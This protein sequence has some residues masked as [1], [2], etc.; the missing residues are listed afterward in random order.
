[1]GLTRMALWAGIKPAN[2]PETIKMTK[3]PVTTP[4][5]TLGLMNISTGPTLSSKEL[6]PKMTKDPNMIPTIP[7]IK[8]RKMDSI[9]IC[10][11][12]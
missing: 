7:D 8:V 4:T 10:F 6:M 3:A 2:S 9:K 5:L 11:F 12:S 1:M